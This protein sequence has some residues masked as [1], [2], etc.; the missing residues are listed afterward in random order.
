MPPVLL[1][2]HHKNIEA[3]RRQESIR[4]TLTMRPDL[5]ENASLTKK[6]QEFLKALREEIHEESAC[7]QEYS[8]IE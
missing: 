3:W 5:L 6:E 2:G 8:V 1:S 7:A 4:R